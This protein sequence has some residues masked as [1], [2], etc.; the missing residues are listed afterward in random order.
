LEEEIQ[1]G[2]ASA[3]KYNLLGLALVDSDRRRA[4]EAF[5]NALRCNLGFG[6]AYLNLADAYLGAPDGAAAKLCLERYLELFPQGE[7]AADARRRFPFV[8]GERR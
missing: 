8:N 2:R 3:E 7:L 1:Q 4:I 6:A 5:K